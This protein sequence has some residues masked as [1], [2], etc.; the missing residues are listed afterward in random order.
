MELKI[1][2]LDIQ[3]GGP[4]VLVINKQFADE[5]LIYGGDRLEIKKREGVKF[6]GIV[7]ISELRVKKDEIWL[8]Y[9]WKKLG[10]N[11]SDLVD[12]R[13]L[14]KPSAINAIARKL[15]GEELSKDEIYDII[16]DITFNE[17]SDI[18]LAIF[19]SGVYT[20][21]MSLEE[22]Y[23]MTRA[24]VKYGQKLNLRKKMIVDKHSIGGIAGNRTTPLI[25]P[26]VASSGLII[27][28]TSSR[29][30]TSPA[31]TA[32]TVESFCKVSFTIKEIKEIIKKTNAC[33][34]WGGSLNLAPADE[35][36]I[37]VEH[38]VSLDPVP[39]L[40]A[41]VMAKKYSVGATHVLI[42]IPIG[43]EAKVQYRD[44]AEHLKEQFIKLGKK[45]GMKVEVMITDGSQPIGNG[46]GPNLEAKDILYIL[47]NDKRGPDLLREKALKM[48]GKILEM[49]GKAKKDGGYDAAE[50]ILT[51]GKAYKKFRQIIREQK[52]DPDIKPDEISLGKYSE[53]IKS[54]ES[55]VVLSVSNKE[56]TKIALALGNPKDKKAGI[57]LNIHIGD[58]VK[59][60]D[61]VF[62]IYSDSVEK[63]NNTKKII[64][65]KKIF[66]VK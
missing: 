15:K 41:S 35:K 27:P 52:G 49:T 28:K 42:D 65:L 1:K 44:E 20:R 8:F 58:K 12:V 51:S 2:M 32:D 63:F 62:T 46:I 36:I 57:Y 43:K 60:G 61:N 21:G 14:P 56:I 4:L 40:L 29:A 37:R 34:V 64:D 53:T 24:M 33:M 3:T 59:R 66:V 7:D 39:Q 38:P 30:I 50:K 6:I 13:L 47:T 23:H 5:N 10:F 54:R 22:I 18:E 55:G 16:H 9:E 19:V 11:D 26:I 31:G 45:L 25:I 17:L 48:A